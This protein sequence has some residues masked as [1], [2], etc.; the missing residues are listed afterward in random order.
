MAPRYH[1][2]DSNLLSPS[3]QLN[4]TVTSRTS[5]NLSFV[6]P[7][8]TIDLEP[9]NG[10]TLDEFHMNT[11]V[12]PEEKFLKSNVQKRSLMALVIPK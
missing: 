9:S 4:F 10:E 12:S 11:S 2:E 6:V 3:F 5:I 1:A 7:A 8:A